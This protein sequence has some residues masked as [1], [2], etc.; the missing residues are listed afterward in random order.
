MKAAI[1]DNRILR[2][3]VSVKGASKEPAPEQAVPTAGE[4]NALADAV[5]EGYEATVILAAW[6]ALRFGEMAALRRDRASTPRGAVK[7]AEKA[8]AA[9]LVR[10]RARRCATASG[11]VGDQGPRRSA[12]KRSP[13]VGSTSSTMTS[14][15]LR[16]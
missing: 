11:W 15:P 3:P 5:P 9:G 12:H 2:S 8:N 7:A 1:D 4:V 14:K 10:S 16:R 13:Y 6:C